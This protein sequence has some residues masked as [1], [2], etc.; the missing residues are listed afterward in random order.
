[1]RFHFVIQA[2]FIVDTEGWYCVTNGNI[3]F[4]SLR[5]CFRSI[6]SLSV[7]FISDRQVSFLSKFVGSLCPSSVFW[8]LNVFLQ[9]LF[10]RS[11]FLGFL[12]LLL[13]QIPF[14]TLGGWHQVKC[15]CRKVSVCLKCVSASRIDF[16]LNLVPLSVQPCLKTQSQCQMFRPWI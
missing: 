12:R 11:F 16:S 6:D 2:S 10:L 13:W 8:H 9:R 1:M 7:N 15:V 14:S 5:F 4:S 3:S